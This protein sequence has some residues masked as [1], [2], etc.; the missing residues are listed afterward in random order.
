[1]QEQMLRRLLAHRDEAQQILNY[2]EET[3]SKN[4]ILTIAMFEYIDAINYCEESLKKQK[5]KE[6]MYV[7]CGC[8]DS[9]AYLPGL[10]RSKTAAEIIA[11]ELNSNPEG[12][13]VSVV[14]MK[15]S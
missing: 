9:V 4:Q 2:L 6:V 13:Q 15:V 3:N 14:E 10:Y 7:L 5:P 8:N 1:M 11:D 12:V